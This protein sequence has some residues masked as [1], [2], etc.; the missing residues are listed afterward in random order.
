MRSESRV[1]EHVGQGPVA[2]TVEQT[3]DSKGPTPETLLSQGVH[4]LGRL[5]EKNP[6]F[7]GMVLPP[8]GSKLKLLSSSSA[9]VKSGYIELLSVSATELRIHIYLD[10]KLLS[11]YDEKQTVSLGQNGQL[12]M[13]VGKDPAEPIFLVPQADATANRLTF[14]SKSGATSS[15]AWNTQTRQLTME[16]PDGVFVFG[17]G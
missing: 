13:R 4:E 11:D 6:E 5:L 14:R 16:T 10:V 3:S 17:Q 7:L 9:M 8:V 2:E 12:S 15:F 1:S